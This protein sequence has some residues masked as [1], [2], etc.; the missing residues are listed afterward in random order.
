MEFG[1]CA[2]ET[3]S[4]EFMAVV[5]WEHRHITNTPLPEYSYRLLRDG[6]GN[7]NAAV[8]NFSTEMPL[9]LDLG[10]RPN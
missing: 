9:T 3:G 1:D 6:G 7:S 2:V 4:I 5:L 10:S 8:R